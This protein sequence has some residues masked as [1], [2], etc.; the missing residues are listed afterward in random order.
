MHAGAGAEAKASSTTL[1]SDTLTSFRPSRRLND[2]FF[3]KPQS[4][5]PASQAAAGSQERHRAPC[6]HACSCMALPL[7]VVL[8][9]THVCALCSPE[10][11]PQVP[12][13]QEVPLQEV[14]ALACPCAG[15]TR[16]FRRFWRAALLTVP[17]QLIQD[18]T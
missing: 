5:C 15:L 9:G 8:T 7:S 17:G 14:A 2:F 18:S 4:E 12:A 3:Q 13:V 11:D 16:Y 10:E 6:I 1:R